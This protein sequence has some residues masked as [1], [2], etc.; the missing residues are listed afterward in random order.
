MRIKFIL[1]VISLSLILFSCGP[2]GGGASDNQD[3]QDSA[4]SEENPDFFSEQEQKD[5]ETTPDKKKSS[6]TKTHKKENAAGKTAKTEASAKSTTTYKGKYHGLTR[7]LDILHMA[8]VQE[9]YLG[10]V[11]TLLAQEYAFNL[12][13]T[14]S[15]V[16]EKE[17]VKV[18]S[19]GLYN[20]G[21]PVKK[22]FKVISTDGKFPRYAKDFGFE[23]RM[24][25]NVKVAD[26]LK[27]KIVLNKEDLTI[28][29]NTGT[30]A[31]ISFSF[32]RKELPDGRKFFKHLDG[33]MFFNE[34]GLSKV[35]L[36]ND[37]A[38]TAHT[39][40]KVTNYRQAMYFRQIAKKAYVVVRLT[41]D[42]EA[43]HLGR[44]FTFE[45]TVNLKDYEKR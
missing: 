7:P 5:L 18:N 30:E 33:K 26:N 16:S 21:E 40:F 22:R 12:F 27:N 45:E 29:K 34:S 43:S 9:N 24:R 2:G 1:F 31:V 36:T 20:P 19:E 13:S 28:E 38:F 3:E 10:V 35:V 41:L 11:V 23:R 8:D 25:R 17:S 32:F 6:S 44:K 39:S 15:V 42:I 4:F 14:A 37:D